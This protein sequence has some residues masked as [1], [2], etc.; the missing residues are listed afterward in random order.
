MKSKNI[1]ALFALFMITLIA[2]SISGSSVFGQRERGIEIGKNY[3][4]NEVDAFDFD[5]IDLNEE[6]DQEKAKDRRIFDYE[7]GYEIKVDYPLFHDSLEK[8]IDENNDTY[9]V[10]VR[11][12]KINSYLASGH[13]EHCEE[14]RNQQGCIDDLRKRLQELADDDIADIRGTL[15]SLQTYVPPGR[16]WKDILP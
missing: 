4:Q 6:Y 14:K 12:F 16:N 9:Y 1:T 2:I 3:T 13:R 7:Q 5:S 8:R 10:G 15:K 11:T